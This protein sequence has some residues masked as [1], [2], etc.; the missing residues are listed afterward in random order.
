M[1]N[2]F[3]G[4]FISYKVHKVLL[5]QLVLSYYE[6]AHNNH[7]QIWILKAIL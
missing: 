2:S 1:K 5:I 7:S 3:L 4:Q 6:S